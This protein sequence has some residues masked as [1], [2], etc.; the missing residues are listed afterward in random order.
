MVKEGYCCELHWLVKS[1]GNAS[2]GT[3]PPRLWALER[4][5]LHVES[6]NAHKCLLKQESYNKLCKYTRD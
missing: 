4:Q 1:K 2:A 6:D 5:A 3:G